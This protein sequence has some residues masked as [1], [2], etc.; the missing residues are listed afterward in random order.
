MKTKVILSYFDVC[1]E[2]NNGLVYYVDEDA[3]NKI[4]SYQKNKNKVVIVT[5]A[6]YPVLS[7]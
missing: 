1:A 7:H 4:R 2:M 3:L 5:D 6:Q